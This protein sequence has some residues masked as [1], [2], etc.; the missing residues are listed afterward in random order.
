MTDFFSGD[1]ILTNEE[2]REALYS[3]LAIVRTAI[4]EAF[5]DWYNPHD[6]GSGYLK[7]CKVTAK[8]EE[9]FL[10]NILDKLERS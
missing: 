5:P 6:F 1:V 2:I 9:S 7:G 4:D 8:L 10:A 3:R